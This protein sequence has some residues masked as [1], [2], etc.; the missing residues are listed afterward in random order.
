M[1]N[2]ANFPESQMNITKE[3]KKDY[4]KRTLGQRGKNKA[5]SKPIKANSK[6]IKANKMPKQSQFK[7]KQTQFQRQKKI[8]LRLPIGVFT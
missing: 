3:M 1:Q 2:K 7:P 6:P 8:L 5:N 4:A